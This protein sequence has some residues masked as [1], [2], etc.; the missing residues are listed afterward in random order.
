VDSHVGSAGGPAGS[1]CRRCR[2]AAAAAILALAAL[3][4][5][6][7][8]AA[9]IGTGVGATPLRLIARAE[10]GRQYRLPSLFV[11]NTGTQTSDYVV[12]V[13][14]VDLKP[15]REVPASWVHVART[16]LRLR[17]HKHALV[18][19]VL[20]V[21]KSAANG[22]YRTDL[23]VGTSTRRPGSGAALGAAAADGLIFTVGGPT[24]YPWSSPWFWVAVFGL[25]AALLL[26]TLVRRLGIRVQLE[27]RTA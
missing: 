27:R 14:H 7:F 8:A 11:V 25:V 4:L 15:G 16:R 2:W 5:P 12:H 18:G 17:A 6:S 10:P 1:R 24:T 23:V 21:P 19:V 22:D 13:R 9:T 3:S 26:R 20:S